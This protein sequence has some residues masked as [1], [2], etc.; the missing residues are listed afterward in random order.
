MSGIFFSFGNLSVQRLKV[1]TDKIKSR[2]CFNGYILVCLYCLFL[3]PNRR[4]P[5]L[6]PCYKKKKKNKKSKYENIHLPLQWRANTRAQLT[7][8]R[9]IS[10]S[11]RWAWRRENVLHAPMTTVFSTTACTY[12]LYLCTY[13]YIRA[14]CI[15]SVVYYTILSSCSAAFTL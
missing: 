11:S 15:H 13:N 4:A 3:N 8:L 5:R 14:T 9:R 2:Y 10:S 7:H 1:C 12:I 6:G